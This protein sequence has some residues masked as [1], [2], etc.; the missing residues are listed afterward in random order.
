MKISRPVR[1]L[2][3]VLLGLA[4]AACGGGSSDPEPITS[5]C[6]IAAQNQAVYETMQQWYFWYEELPEVDPASFESPEALLDA[7]RFEPLDR[8]SYITTQAEEE[9]LF[10][11]SQFVG[12]GFRSVEDDGVQVAVDVFEGGPAD[13]AGLVR[14]SR[15]L[16]VDGVPIEEV[17]ASPEG[18]SGSLGPSE[19]GYQFELTF[20]NPDG[21][22]LNPIL[23]K[24]VVTIPPV[25]GTRVF[26]VDGVTTG[27]LV[28]RN[29]TEPG[30]PALNTAF[31]TFSAAGVT[32]LIVDLRYNGG[33][34]ISVTEHFADLLASRTA[35]GQA[36][37]R[38]IYNDQNSNRNQTFF[39]TSDPPDRALLLD[40]VV[41]I[42][43][44]STASASE[45]LVNSLPPYITAAT[46]GSATF[47]KPVG[48]LGFLFCE[49]VLR[50]VSFETVNSLNVGGYFDGIEP[51]CAAG[52][53]LDVPFGTPGEASFDASVHWLQF[54]FC[55]QADIAVEF[56]RQR[57]FRSDPPRYRPNNAF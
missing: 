48:Q 35:P 27:Y 1:R 14:G 17:L 32:Q 25:T 15:I 41:L 39:F 24:A 3:A 6:S 55:P 54:G 2:P 52:D 18:F 8:F 37:A 21:E 46:V 42:T 26:E 12:V 51:L 44:E 47:G 50:P 20:E 16:A 22:V 38:Y 11:E 28:F 31:D 9:A 4:L 40:K 43:T 36:F 56:E 29:F 5:E 49:Q 30:V 57:E 34:L 23:T 53:T 13:D 10:G 7:L 19:I 33:G 45:I